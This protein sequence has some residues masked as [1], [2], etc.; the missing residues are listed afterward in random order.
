[1]THADFN[2][3]QQWLGFP[4]EQADPDHFQLLRVPR[5]G[6][7]ESQL[8]LTINAGYERISAQL[9]RLL[10]TDQPVLQQ[11]LW[12]RIE[13]ARQV[14]TDPEQRRQ[15]LSQLEPSARSPQSRPTP[16]KRRKPKSASTNTPKPEANRAAEPTGKRQFLG[17]PSVEERFPPGAKIPPQPLP[18]SGEEIG[19]LEEVKQSPR[20][21]PEVVPDKPRSVPTAKLFEDFE[22]TDD[23]VPFAQPISNTQGQL[24]ATTSA[25]PLERPVQPQPKVKKESEF[26]RN[27]RAKKKAA[28]IRALLQVGLTG[29]IVVIGF[30]LLTNLETLKAKLGFQPNAS[31]PTASALSQPD[32]SPANQ[33]NPS[34]QPQPLDQP[35]A[36]ATPEPP[37]INETGG[38]TVSPAADNKQTGEN[39]EQD[40]VATDD[41]SLVIEANG[42]P[43]G[44]EPAVDPLPAPPAITPAD[45]NRWRTASWL[46]RLAQHQLYRR[47]YDDARQRLEQAKQL[48]RPDGEHDPL[49]ETPGQLQ[50]RITTL[51]KL[52]TDLDEFLQQVSDAAIDVPG[53]LNI[54]ANDQVVGLVDA[55]RKSIVLRQFGINHRYDYRHMPPALAVQLVEQTGYPDNAKWYRRKAAFYAIEQSMAGVL[56]EKKVNELIRYSTDRGEDCAAIASFIEQPNFELATNEQRIIIDPILTSDWLHQLRSKLGYSDPAKLKANEADRI[57]NQ[58]LLMV[59]DSDRQSVELLFEV[60]RLAIIAR[61]VSLMEATVLELNQHAVVDAPEIFRAGLRWMAREELEPQQRDDL[62]ETAI[63]FL[64]D[65]GQAEGSF[66]GRQTTSVTAEN[67]SLL[68]RSLLDIASQPLHKYRLQQL[69]L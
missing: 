12:Q 53:N 15:Y 40:E 23:P 9:A 18:P 13:T 29:V 54:N 39:E 14:L 5:Q 7:E 37:E 25:Q 30:L 57:V 6:M 47:N 34:D 65:L 42:S 64:I 8:R 63:G 50:S 69:E 26:D 60:Y 52:T 45:R 33:T 17:P 68:R 16:A 20:I 38:S 32:D 22:L 3:F 62:L 4:P 10:P 28:T 2:P 51:Q 27:R 44:S 1:M 56:D 21:E 36:N 61:N 24:T 35:G 46:I 55:D 31:Q 43:P 19:A 41:P 66:W 48:L 59:S 67:L 49:P 58:L 11:Q